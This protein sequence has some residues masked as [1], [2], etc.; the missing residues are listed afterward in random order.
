MSI[1]ATEPTTNLIMSKFTLPLISAA[2]L[3]AMSAPAQTSVQ[4]RSD[5][6]NQTL[7]VMQT[8]QNADVRFKAAPGKHLMPPPTGTADDIVSDP[9]GQKFENAIRSDVSLNN[10]MGM[11]E[12]QTGEAF[13]G[14]FV[15]ADNGNI[16]IRP[17]TTYRNAPGYI[18]LEKQ[19]DGT[20]V[21]HT[22]QVF[23]D[24]DN[25]DGTHTLA[26][27]TRF[28]LKRTEDG[29]NYYEAEENEDGTFNTDMKFTYE[30]GVIRQVDQRV[31][32]QGLPLEL[33]AMTDPNGNWAIWGSGCINMKALP[34]DMKPAALPEDIVEHEVVFGY[35]TLDYSTGELTFNN[36][37]YKYVTSPS[38]PDAVYIS[39]PSRWLS[40]K[41]VKG[42]IGADK[43]WTFEK[44]YLGTYPAANMHIWFTPATFQIIQ[45]EQNG[46]VSY[47][48]RL[49]QS[50][51][52][53][54]RYDEDKV[55]YFSADND[56]FEV[57]ASPASADYIIES[58][59]V[60]SIH[61]YSDNVLNPADPTFTSFTPYME[62]NK[63]GYMSFS[64]P[65]YDIDG[66]FIST[67]KMYYRLFINKDETEP[68]V[69]TPEEYKTLTEN[70]TDVP[71]N[72]S[73]YSFIT[74]YN[75]NHNIYF[76]RSDVN[77]WGVQSVYK[78]GDEEKT[79]NVVW[80]E[81]TGVDKITTEAVEGEVEWYDLLGRRVNNPER[82]IFIKKSG[83]KIQ[84]VVL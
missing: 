18:E 71:Y 65:N 22:P 38:E 26:W 51:A 69:L 64:I 54:F 30:N 83:S 33:L 10:F 77:Y 52:I 47:G 81:S 43:S 75:A 66:N 17:I 12:I 35:K 13:I 29:A 59:A 67:D 76:Y 50:D 31:S 28:I 82:G 46:M 84:K 19:E 14:D 62:V 39:I 79:S 11:P 7:S 68:Y 73:D 56:A 61:G 15:I 57:N 2:L 60:P 41:W 25:Y 37:T 1:F 27:A 44:Q 48:M 55:S 45:G 9:E 58:Y 24:Q 53:V 49:D 5:A 80:H 4:Y 6:E 36:Q 3:T 8:K 40:D 42:T 70:M 72:F 63:F 21:A 23:Y 20:Y 78:D 74:S 34:E 32:E 16:W